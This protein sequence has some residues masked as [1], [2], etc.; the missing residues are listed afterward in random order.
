MALQVTKLEREFIFKKDGKDVKLNDPNPELSAD[1]VM[2]FYSSQYPELTTS[3][4]EGPK[5]EKDKAV[6]NFKTT[7]GTKG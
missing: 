3:T 7:V 2:K 5:I 4:S 1:E 6:Y